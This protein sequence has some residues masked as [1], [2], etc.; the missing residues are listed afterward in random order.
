LGVLRGA[1]LIPKPLYG[2]IP[3]G[4]TERRADC[5]QRRRLD[6]VPAQP[7]PAAQILRSWHDAVR[8]QAGVRH[9]AEDTNAVAQPIHLGF[10]LRRSALIEFLHYLQELGVNPV[11]SNL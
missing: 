2:R 1:D 6:H 5:R 11:I 10:R 4:M 9:L 8:D 3:I 7:A